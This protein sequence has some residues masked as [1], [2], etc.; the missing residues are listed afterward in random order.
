MKPERKS[1]VDL[2]SAIFQRVNRAGVSYALMRNYRQVL[3]GTAKDIDIL[4]AAEDLRRFSDQIEAATGLSPEWSI[5]QVI[6][7]RYGRRVVLFHRDEFSLLFDL[8]SVVQ[9]QSGLAPG[10]LFL[11]ETRLSPEGIKLLGREQFLTCLYLHSLFKSKPEY[12]LTLETAFRAEQELEKRVRGRVEDLNRRYRDGLFRRVIRK[13]TDLRF[14]LGYFNPPGF[15]VVVNGPDGVGKT[16]ALEELQG[17]LTRLGVSSRVKHLG[18][19]TGMLPDRPRGRSRKGGRPRRATACPVNP[20]RLRVVVDLPRLIYH[21]LDIHLYYWLV[22]RK[23]Q[24]AGGW[25]IADKY[26]TYTVKAGEMGFFVPEKLVRTIYRVLPRPD[27]Y[28]LFWNSPEEIARRK[29]E[30]TPREAKNHAL[31]L[32]Q[33]S[34]YSR[35][36]AEIKTDRSIPR[37]AGEVLEILVGLAGERPGG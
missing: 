19:K 17:R 6:N 3:S 18:G 9:L 14:W 27:L 1:R 31:I 8:R 29:G 32:E 10:R 24:S 13:M 22:I 26:F 25:F 16:T 35:R 5:I 30:L 21:I 28:L 23:F 2:A 7:S 20:R 34:R 15:F 12:A 37:V 36:R 4:V 11:T 33:I